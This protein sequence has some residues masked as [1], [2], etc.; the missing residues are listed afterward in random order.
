MQTFKLGDMV[1]GW[2]VGNFQPTAF[3]TSACEVGFK[4]HHKGEPWP[5]HYHAIAT[6]INCVLRGII[7]INDKVFRAGDIFVIE[8]REVTQAEF[9]TDCELIVVKV[10]GALNDKFIVESE[11]L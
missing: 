10:P 5:K 11:A 2:L 8:P 9:L 3:S 7:S 4:H 1:G 6:E